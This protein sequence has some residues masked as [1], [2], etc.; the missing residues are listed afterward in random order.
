[1]PLYEYRCR[2]CDTVFDARLPMSRLDEPQSCPSGHTD[3]VRLLSV[4]A[5]TGRA[6][7]WPSAP[8]G[9]PC[10]SACACHPG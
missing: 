4:F 3:A 6:G 10:G 1:V 5:S 8:A 9:A 2:Q 7:S